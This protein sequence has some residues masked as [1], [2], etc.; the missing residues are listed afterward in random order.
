MGNGLQ[1]VLKMHGK[2]SVINKHG[3]KVIHVWDY[4][5]NIPRIKS[6]MTEEEVRKSDEAR[7]KHSLKNNIDY[8]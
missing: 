6:E 1:R 3:K 8:E 5:K 2:I 7:M 4:A